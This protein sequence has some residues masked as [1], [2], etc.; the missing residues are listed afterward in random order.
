M[1]RIPLYMLLAS[2]SAWLPAE[3]LSHCT[4]EIAPEVKIESPR[5][6]MSIQ[7]VCWPVFEMC[8]QDTF[9]REK[10][11]A[12]LVAKFRDSRHAV[13]A[14]ADSLRNYPAMDTVYYNGQVY[15]VDTLREESVRIGIHAELKGELPGKSFQY[16]DRF[17]HVPG[18]P[19][20]TSYTALLDTPM[21][22]FFDAHDSIW[23]LGIGPLD[24]CFYEPTAY[25]IKDGR[26]FK[27]ASD[28][29]RRMPGVSVSLEEFF[30]AAGLPGIAAPP[31][32][33]GR[34]SIRRPGLPPAAALS[35]RNPD[36]LP[37][38]LK[39]R[40]IDRPLRAPPGRYF[41]PYREGAAGRD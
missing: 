37:R 30:A 1:R 20:A 13:F 9:Y 26:I 36:A 23:Q 21:L 27:K 28:E 39:G 25:V 2:A 24:G 34:T 35:G 6:G 40:R 5:E 12:E 18:Q 10:L 22:A 11:L 4:Q 15:Y 32:R 16:K 7:S 41:L 33:P 17:I 3:G 31:V 38:D 8:Y 29:S 14:Y 19:F